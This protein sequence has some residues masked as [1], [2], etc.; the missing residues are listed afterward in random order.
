MTQ[1][2]LLRAAL[3][4]S[5]ADYP[6]SLSAGEEPQNL[7]RRTSRSGAARWRHSL[8]CKSYP[9]LRQARPRAGPEAAMRV[10]KI[11]AQCVLQFTP[12][13]AAGCVLHRPV[14]RVI[15]CSELY[16][17]LA[18][19]RKPSF[20]FESFRSRIF[21]LL[22]EG[23]VRGQSK[24]FTERVPSEP[25]SL[26]SAVRPRSLATGPDRGLG[27]QRGGEFLSGTPLQA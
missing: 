19:S 27:H 1:S 17:S 18:T 24:S 9:T 20:A 6:T 4:L 13:L 16:K 2:R 7:S 5:R 26:R 15:H 11:S 22:T 25:R 12:S 10:R 21:P 23:K 8:L 14:S 3:R